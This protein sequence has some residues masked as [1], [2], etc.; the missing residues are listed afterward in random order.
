MLF[1]IRNATS[2]FGEVIE[3]YPILQKYN[4]KK[5]KN[6]ETIE[7]NSLEELMKLI[8]DVKNELVISKDEILIYDDYI[9]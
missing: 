4:Y 3:E 7:I 6:K 1:K 2:C 8:K 5:T 9:E